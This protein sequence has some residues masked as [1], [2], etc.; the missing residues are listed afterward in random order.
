MSEDTTPEQPFTLLSAAAGIL[1]LR[2]FAH[3]LN[4]AESMDL[5]TRTL[6]L[7]EKVKRMVDERDALRADNAMLREGAEE[8][9]LAK[10]EADALL[11]EARTA[12][13]RRGGDTFH[14]IDCYLAGGSTSAG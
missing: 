6:R 1:H 9:R 11:D 13:A 14:R 12:L 4:V 2:T 10:A 7:F 5:D 3:P 8:W